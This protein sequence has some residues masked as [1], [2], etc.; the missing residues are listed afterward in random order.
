MVDKVIFRILKKWIFGFIRYR[1][2]IVRKYILFYGRGVL[3][4]QLFQIKLFVLLI[5]FDYFLDFIISFYVIQDLLFGKKIIKLLIYEV[6]IVFNVIRMLILEFIV[7][8]YFV[9]VEE[10]KFILFSRRILLNIFLVCV[11]F[12][13]KSL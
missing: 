4:L 7:G 2:I 1:F 9:Y 13:R 6:V 10:F 12:I 3:V 5:Q 8:Q 11:V